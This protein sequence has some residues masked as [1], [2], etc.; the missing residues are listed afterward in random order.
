MNNDR[1]PERLCVGNIQERHYEGLP[2]RYEADVHVC[3]ESGQ[4]A[5]N[6]VLVVYMGGRGAIHSDKESVLATAQAIVDAYN[7]ECEGYPG[8]AHDFEMCQAHLRRAVEFCTGRVN[9]GTLEAW[10]LVC[11][12][13]DA[14]AEDRQEG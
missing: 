6:C 8:I 5:G 10:K 13:P 12:T 7:H 9:P 11:D 3:D 2:L 1:T 14:S 4:S